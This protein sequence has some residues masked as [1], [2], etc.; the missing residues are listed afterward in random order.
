[1]DLSF[2]LSKKVIELIGRENVQ[3]TAKQIN[4]IIKLLIQEEQLNNEEKMKKQSIQKP[5]RKQQSNT[6]DDNNKNIP[7]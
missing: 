2:L 1:M 5:D 4:E 6:N 3:L 7:N